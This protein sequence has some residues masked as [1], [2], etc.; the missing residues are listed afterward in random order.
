MIH[1]S[2]FIHP[3][4]HVEDSTVGARSKIWQFASVIRGAVIGEDCTVASGALFDGSVCGDRSILCQNLAAGPGF[5]IGND[6]FIGP[7]V[8][9]CNDLWPRASKEGFDMEKLR[10]GKFAIIIED[11]A[12]IGANAVVLPGVVIGKG[13]IVA[14]GAAVEKSILPGFILQRSGMQRRIPERGF[15]RMR[16]CST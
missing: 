1:P 6:V 5:K 15:N 12:T 4:A 7:N 13:A 16:F 3:K 9:L 14:A 10:Q 8:T 11:G 2:A